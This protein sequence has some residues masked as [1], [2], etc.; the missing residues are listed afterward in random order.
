MQFDATF[1]VA[2]AFIAFIAV[3]LYFKVP[4]M[5]AKMLDERADRIKSELDEAQKLR[6][7]AQAMFADYQRR[8]RDALATAEEI[9]AKAKED[10]E[11]IRKESE[12][13]LQATLKRRQEL[14]EAKIRQAEEKALAEVQSIAVEVSIAAAEKLMKDNLKAKEA[15]ALIDQSIKD[16]GSQL[17]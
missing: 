8:Q 14:A 11:I 13:E 6:E 7:D 3:V 2:V 5:L 17:N 10:A 15:G 16:L 1:W 12:A 4:A 9:V